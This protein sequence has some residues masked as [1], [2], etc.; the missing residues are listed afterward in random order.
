MTLAP[1]IPD[2]AARPRE[3]GVMLIECMVY[4]SL[5]LVLLGVAFTVFHACQ[6]SYVGLMRNA[7]DITQTLRAGE[8]WRAD[9]RSASAPPRFAEN[10][11]GPYVIIPQPDGQVAYQ[12]AGGSLWRFAAPDRPAE[13]VLSGVHGSVMEADARTQVTAYRWS[14][15]LQSRHKGAHIPPRFVFLAVPATSPQP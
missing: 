3:R 11:Q 2:G 5:Y 12:L 6:D 9:V 7:G 15:E 10:D 4:I 8:R 13:E 14:V 1:V